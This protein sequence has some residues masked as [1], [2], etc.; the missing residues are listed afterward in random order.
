MTGRP[1]NVLVASSD[2]QFCDCIAAVDTD[3]VAIFKDRLIQQPSFH[4]KVSLGEIMLEVDG[5]ELNNTRRLCD[6]DMTEESFVTM[7]FGS[8]PSS[9]NS[10]DMSENVTTGVESKEI[11]IYVGFVSGDRRGFDIDV[12]NSTTV[13]GLKALIMSK[14]PE[15]EPDKQRIFLNGSNLHDDNTLAHYRIED[16]ANLFVML[17]ESDLIPS[18]EGTLLLYVSYDGK[19]HTV[20]IHHGSDATIRQVKKLVWEKTGILPAFQRLNFDG[21]DLD[22]PDQKLSERDIKAE[23]LLYLYQR[24]ER[25]AEEG[26]DTR[27]AHINLDVAQSTSASTA[28]EEGDMITIFLMEPTM[29][30]L[31]SRM[32][33]KLKRNEPLSQIFRA[34]SSRMGTPA[35]NLRFLHEIYGELPCDCELSPDA[36]GLED[37][38]VIMVVRGM[39]DQVPMSPLERAGSNEIDLTPFSGPGTTITITIKGIER[40]VTAKLIKETTSLQLIFVYF[41]EEQG[42]EGDLLMY[43]CKGRRYNH[44]IDKTASQC[45]I[46]DGDTIH[47]LWRAG[48]EKKAKAVITKF[49]GIRVRRQRARELRVEQARKTIGD[50]L[51]KC[52]ASERWRIQRKSATIIQKTARSYTSRMRWYKL[53]VS[54]KLV[55]TLVRGHIARKIH[56]DAVQTRLLEYRHFA[57]VWKP[58]ADLAAKQASEPQSLTGWAFVREAINLKKTVDVDEDGNLVDTHEKLNKA[59]AGALE[60]TGDI[61]NDLQ[62]DDIESDSENIEPDNHRSQSI[63]WS[64]FQVTHHVTKFIKNGDAKFR[65]IFVKKIKQ[66][67]RGERSHKLQKPLQ[68]CES[69]IYETYLENR[70]G[71]RIL[72]TQEGQGLVIWFVCQHKSVSRLAKLI[73]DAKNRSARQQLPETFIAEMESDMCPV[74]ERVEV[75]LDPIGNVPLKL[76]DM[77]FENVDDIT[78]K[79]WAPRMHLTAEERAV[80]EAKGTVLLLGRSG[81]GELH[82]MQSSNNEFMLTLS[83]PLKQRQNCMHLQQNRVRSREARTQDRIYADVHRQI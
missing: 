31:D 61:E 42:I 45:G 32:P 6:Y 36:M 30:E 11:R 62:D 34:Y 35:S 4:Y 12:E 26:Y 55:Q 50:F 72:W 68:G 60:E 79:S 49:I 64:Q 59:L 14:A 15:Y 80:V 38:C 46:E 22:R 33:F 43:R 3:T 44:S 71:W 52:I 17:K 19:I 56:G 74:E 8:D 1:L 73:D 78:D 75:K 81:T 63:D 25:D 82:E 83:I 65:E 5:V 66:L 21:G 23:S 67:G 48:E 37:G 2:G 77:S 47:A 24:R 54:V 39:Q 10:P 51:W 76:Y 28:A 40:N 20:C 70:S 57:S 27:P 29:G 9:D 16:G 18:V 13:E 7:S 41:S 53:A 58:V 69:V